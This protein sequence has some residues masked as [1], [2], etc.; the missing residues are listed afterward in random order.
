[1]RYMYYC[2]K[3]DEASSSEVNKESY[4]CPYCLKKYR[5]NYITY[6]MNLSKDEW[7]EM[8][9]ADKSEAK[10]LVLEKRKGDSII[11]EK[12]RHK[13]KTGF[14]ICVIIAI[15]ITIV[16]LLIVNNKYNKAVE[17]VNAGDRDKAISLFEEV[18]WYKDSR[19]I[20][21]NIYYQ[22][23]LELLDKNMY[24]DAFQCFQKGYGDN[25]DK[26]TEYS[27]LAAEIHNIPEDTTLDSLVKRV[28][29]LNNFNDADLLLNEIPR[30]EEFC[31]KMGT[32]WVIDRD[33]YRDGGKEQITISKNFKYIISFYV[34]GKI[35][36][37]YSEDIKW[38][39]YDGKSG[40]SEHS[41]AYWVKAEGKAE[42]KGTSQ[43]VNTVSKGKVCPSCNGS[44]IVKY[45]YGDSDLEALLTGHD[46]YTLGECPMCNGNG[47]VD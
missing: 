7:K 43:S 35:D 39:V 13:I 29:A 27:E 31:S 37:T 14:K 8:S 22:K 36:N 17:C 34:N 16:Y 20:L 47:Y 21:R 25:V 32:W 4:V 28:K 45:N 44:K 11:K 33:I 1:M 41:N 5:K 19:V 23:G 12:T 40:W 9:D 18:D 30:Y 42:E 2:P 26:Y 6:N 10:K 46:P 38:V 24:E 3:C 15:L